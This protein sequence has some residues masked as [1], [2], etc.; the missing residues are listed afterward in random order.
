LAQEYFISGHHAWNLGYF[1][2]TPKFLWKLYEQFVPHV[3]DK[4]AKIA[5]SWGTGKFE[6]VL[7]EVYPTIE[8]IHFDNAILE[9]LDPKDAFVISENIEWSDIGAWEALKEALEK[10]EEDNVVKGNALVEDTKDSL[11]FNFTKQVVVG[12]DL[13]DMVVVNTNDV[14]LVCP[15]GSVPKIKK[16][17]EKL[18]GTSYEHLA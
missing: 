11:I 10:H 18:N 13:D 14:I 2:T 16:F 5:E 15:K 3:Y 4:L 7:E 1:V 6:K 9:N 12:I 8:K 17:V